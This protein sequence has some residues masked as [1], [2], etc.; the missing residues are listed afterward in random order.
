MHPCP[1]SWVAIGRAV[2]Y[3][4]GASQAFSVE[5]KRWHCISL[6]HIVKVKHQYDISHDKTATISAVH[7]L[8]R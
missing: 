5:I 2:V 8:K 1:G 3:Y 6:R 7:K 4:G